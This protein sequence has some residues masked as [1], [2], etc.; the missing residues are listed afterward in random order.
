MTYAWTVTT[1]PTGSKAALSSPTAVAP[2]F[3]AD[4]AGTYVVSLT[5][6]DGRGNSNTATARTVAKTPIFTANCASCHSTAVAQAHIAANGGLSGG[7]CA[8]CHSPGKEV[9][10]HWY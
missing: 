4:V 8:V 1:R 5:V 7:G 2:T 3:L 6:N 9:F 10:Y